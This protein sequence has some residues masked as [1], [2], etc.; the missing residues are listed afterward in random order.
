MQIR[1]IKECDIS[2]LKNNFGGEFTNFHDNR[3]QDQQERKGFY[4]VG[5]IEEDPIAHVFV[6]F[7]KFIKQIGNL[8]FYLVAFNVLENFQSQGIGT[9]IIKFIEQMVKEKFKKNKLHLAVGSN[10]FRGI[11]F[12]QRNG[13]QKFSKPIIFNSNFKN[14][15]GEIHY[16]QEEVFLMRKFL[17]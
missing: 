2:K 7:N 1:L 11:K 14:D 9:L 6:Y 13:F 3:F 5:L 4:V 15:Y 12:Y 10:N 8:D 17:I 16:W